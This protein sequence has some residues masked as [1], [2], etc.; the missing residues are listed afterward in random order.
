L[1]TFKWWRKS[2]VEGGSGFD[3]VPTF[4]PKGV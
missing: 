1:R 4:G 2:S 3:R